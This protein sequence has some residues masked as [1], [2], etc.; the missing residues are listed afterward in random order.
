M[1]VVV[2]LFIP[3]AMMPDSDEAETG[4]AGAR[5]RIILN[6]THDKILQIN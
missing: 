1:I 2:N 3:F 5:L 4:K 6:S